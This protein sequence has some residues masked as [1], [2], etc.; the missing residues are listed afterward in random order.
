MAVLLCRDIRKLCH[1][2]KF[3]TKETSQDKLVGT[4]FFILRQISQRMTRSK[5]EICHDIF[6]VCCDIKFKGQ[7][8]N[9]GRLCRDIEVSCSDNHN[10]MDEGTLSQHWILLSRQ[11]LRTTERML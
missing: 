8:S 3:Q 1:D 6:K 9:A 11:R 2:I 4:K 10:K 5:Q 7:H